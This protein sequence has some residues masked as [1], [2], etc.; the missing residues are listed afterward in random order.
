MFGKQ[1]KAI[2]SSS[3]ENKTFN[4]SK[5]INKEN[6]VKLGFTL[7]VD[8]KQELLAFLELLKE[9]QIVVEKEINNR[10]K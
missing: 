5:E 7:R 9:A 10:F 2:Q 4:F 1:K 6:Q 8:V 3:V